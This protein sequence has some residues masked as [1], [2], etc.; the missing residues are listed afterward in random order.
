MEKKFLKK[1]IARSPEDLQYISACCSLAKVKI[2]DI[3]Y[4]PENKIF[5]ISIERFSKEREKK[6]GKIRSI[7][8]FEYIDSSKS[9][10]I[11]QSDVD[12]TYELIAIDLFKKD[13]KT[14]RRRT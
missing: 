6:D 14:F 13:N 5:L 11:D 8:K 7:V 4:L 9:K 2:G 12:L 3:K 1:I 10:N